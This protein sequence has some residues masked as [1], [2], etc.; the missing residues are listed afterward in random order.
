[1][2]NDSRTTAARTVLFPPYGDSKDPMLRLDN[3]AVH[4]AQTRQ[5]RI[6]LY[7]YLQKRIGNTEQFMLDGIE[8]P[9]RCKLLVKAEYTNPSGSHYDREMIRFLR[10]LE[11]DARSIVPGRTRMLETTTGNSG[12]AFAWLCR[13]LGYPAPVIIIPGDM[14]RARRAQIESFGAELIES[15]AGEYITGIEQSFRDF[16]ETA[17]SKGLFCPQHW[18][19][20]KHG[21]AAMRDCSREVMQWAQA[22]GIDMDFFMLAL[23]NGSS[24]RGFSEGL[25]KRVKLLGMEPAESPVVAE[26]L[27]LPG[28]EEIRPPGQRNHR[29]IGTGPAEQR[30]IYRNMKA[31][32]ERLG[33]DKGRI[34][35]SE[36]QHNAIVH[37]TTEECEEWQRRLA[38]RA[39]RHVGMSS[40][41]CV[42]A[43][44][45]FI[46]E[47]GVRNRTFGTIFYD[48]AWK[49]LD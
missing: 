45:R 14:P 34:Q 28:F 41:G 3:P 23:G 49:Y 29:I 32:S 11:L 18:E 30:Q 5:E 10:W 1:M 20:E 25:P 4:A 43:V 16:H 21:V 37:V 7:D 39:L 40:A 47:T 48:P 22:E 31:A 13:A 9:N 44:I 38:D 35:I 27:G 6:A 36:H 24:A 26:Y 19:D 12:S 46:E 42:R 2:L 8:L 33:D 17:E 15:P